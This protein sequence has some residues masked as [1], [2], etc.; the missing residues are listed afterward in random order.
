MILLFGSEVSPLAKCGGGGLSGRPL[1]PLMI[2]YLSS[3]R[4][5]GWEKPIIAGGGIL[6]QNNVVNAFAHGADAIELGSV[7]LLKPWRIRSLIQESN[8]VAEVS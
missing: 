2:D 3:L 4:A 5:A 1:F 6:S 7:S 8:H